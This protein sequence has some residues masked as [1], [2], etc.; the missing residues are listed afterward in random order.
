[1]KIAVVSMNVKAKKCEE[2]FA[3]MK[4]RIEEARMQEADMI[5]FPQNA[6]SGYLLSD[7]WKDD[8]WCRY[9]DGFNEQ[10]TAMSEDIAI[11]WGNIRY[12]NQRRFNAAFFAYQG[13][14]HMR[15]KKNE[16]KEYTNN[17]LYFENNPINSAI[18]FK[19]MVMALNFGKELQIADLNINL[20]AHP[21]DMD[22][23]REYKGNVV[24][25]N[26]C[27]A[28]NSGKQVKAMEGASYVHLNQKLLYEAAYFTDTMDI[29][30]LHQQ[31]EVSKKE[32]SLLDALIM[33]IRAFDADVFPST[34]PWVV[35]L[36]GGLDSSVTAALLVL[37]L[38]KERVYGYNMPTSYNSEQTMDNAQQEAQALGI[39]YHKGS[40]SNMVASMEE[41][42]K[43]AF[44]FDVETMPSL[45][46]ENLQA[47]I[48]GFVL[49]GISSMLKGVVVNNANMVEAAL[50]YCTLY[51]DSIGALSLIGDL[52]KVTLF[53]V[54]R[55]INE[56]CGKEVV[57]C[58]LLPEVYENHI[59]WEMM[60]SAELKD[61]QKDP[62][63][64]FYH[65]QLLNMIRLGDTKSSLIMKYRKGVLQE[66]LGKWLEYYQIHDEAAFLQDLEW[67]LQ[68]MERNAFKR[69]QLPPCITL[70]AETI[71]GRISSQ[72][73]S[74]TMDQKALKAIQK[75]E[76]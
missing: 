47:R 49:N 17:A 56:R 35:G 16:E 37:A 53:K 21:F 32:A 41:Q 38:G 12:R 50:G 66:Q 45:V 15:V 43:E 13:Q 70:H 33:A 55:E 1:M 34:M 28:Q 23:T 4:K 5:V 8:A 24:Y 39:H 20:D 59:E 75:I 46:K 7:Q 36:S 73:S 52:D 44:G 64:W 63:K 76:S 27:G 60:P 22:E 48:R 68:T 74:G 6:I 67:L 62:M 9:V 40:I 71:I 3:Y 14:T 69:L 61:A 19:D 10:L 51:G 58:N 31:E 29:V 2:N 57:P 65:D 72:G 11:V 26:A 54:A 25:V 18:E 30:D 42:F